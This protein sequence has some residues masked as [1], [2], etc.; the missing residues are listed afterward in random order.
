[1]SRQR[2]SLV[3]GCWLLVGVTGCGYSFRSNVPGH[4]RTVYIQ[5]FQ[6]K[7]DITSEVSDLNRFKIYRPLLETDVTN[8]VIKQYN[9]DGNLRVAGAQNADAMLVGE[10]VDFRR[11]ALRFSD[12]SNPEEFRLSIVVNLAFYDLHTHQLLWRETNFTGDTTFFVSGSLTE[13]ERKAL[14]RAIEDLAKRV[15]ER[16]VEGW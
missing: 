7:I 12:S 1:M 14:D 8:A 9:F 5:P 16:S 4:L 2:A 3:A 13:S 11:D 6:N 10:L 15:V